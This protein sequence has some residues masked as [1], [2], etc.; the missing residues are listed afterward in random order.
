MSGFEALAAGLSGF[1]GAVTKRG[2]GVLFHTKK[3]R[4]TSPTP[5]AVDMRAA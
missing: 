2:F 4:E 3:R 1:T 5:F